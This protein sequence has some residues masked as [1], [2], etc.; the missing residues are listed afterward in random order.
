MRVAVGCV[1]LSLAGT[2]GAAECNPT[3]LLESYSD[4][5]KVAA[6]IPWQPQY[7]DAPSW[8]IEQG[9]PPLPIS[10]AISKAL[11]WAKTKNKRED[12]HVGNVSIWPGGCPDKWSYL[13]HFKAKELGAK[14]AADSAL[15]LMDGTVL[16]TVPVKKK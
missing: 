5:G 7:L 4:D 14:L 13:I 10:T 11:A 8:N 2:C 3:S 12:I 16:G 9:E 15:V 6:T 1:L